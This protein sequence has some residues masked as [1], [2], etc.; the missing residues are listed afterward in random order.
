MATDR[1]RYSCL[2]LRARKKGFGKVMGERADISRQ[3]GDR[4]KTNPEKRGISRQGVT[5]RKVMWKEGVSTDK[6]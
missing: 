4:E 3:R 2:S 5:E 1:P 6:G